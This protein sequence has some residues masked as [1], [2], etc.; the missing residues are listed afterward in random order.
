MHRDS[1]AAP[2]VVGASDLDVQAPIVTVAFSDDG[3][4]LAVVAGKAALVLDAST[5]EVTGKA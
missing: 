5:G 4:H 2:T 3:A 1:A